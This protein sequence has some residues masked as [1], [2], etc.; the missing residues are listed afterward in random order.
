MSSSG[1]IAKHEPATTPVIEDTT[2]HFET[3]EGDLITTDIPFTLFTS[4]KYQNH[5]VN[6]IRIFDDSVMTLLRSTGKS[7]L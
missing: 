5:L 4:A 1:T 6:D 3:T 2:I 7:Y